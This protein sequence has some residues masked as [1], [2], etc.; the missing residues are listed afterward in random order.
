VDRPKKRQSILPVKDLV[1]HSFRARFE[2]G[3]GLSSASAAVLLTEND[4]T[5]SGDLRAAAW[6]QFGNA[7]RF[8]GKFRQAEAALA[9]AS[10]FLTA[11]SDPRTRA[12]FLEITSS[13]HRARERFAESEDC[14]VQAI[15]I[16]KTL[17][18][19][20]AEARGLVLLGLNYYDAALFARSISAY[21]SALNLLD[22]NSDTLL[23]V[24]VCHGLIATMWA[25]GRSQAAAKA[26][27][28]AEPIFRVVSENKHL[29]GKI[30]W[31]KARVFVALG[32][33]AKAAEAFATARDYLTE[34]S[35]HDL[36]MLTSEMA[37]A[38]A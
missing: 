22:E 19:R 38:R 7:L 23:Y 27:D 28:V 26:F 15:E 4:P 14:L 25:A 20:Q 10:S 33:K 16:H 11:D 36:E 37:A 2:D 34:L 32:D 3:R 24:S 12:N 18:D 29:V 9:R 21:Q 30:A 31:L 6:T 35:D 17:G 5:L 1:D 13:L 8:S